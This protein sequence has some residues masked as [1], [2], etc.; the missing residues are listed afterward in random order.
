[1]EPNEERQ[2]QAF[3]P[4]RLVRLVQWLR[5]LLKAT[6]WHGMTALM[7]RIGFVL[8]TVQVFCID[9]QAERV[10]VLRTGEYAAGY[11]PVQGL[12][13]GTLSLRL[14]PLRADVREDAR[15]ELVEEALIEAPPLDAFLVAERYREGPYR[16]FDCTVLVIFCRV[17]ELKLRGETGEG[18]PCWLPLSAA[19]AAFGNKTLRDM[20]ADWRDAPVA[21]TDMGARS[22]GGTSSR[23]FLIGPPDEVQTRPPPQHDMSGADTITAALDRLWAMPLMML[24]AAREL[25]ARGFDEVYQS[26]PKYARELWSGMSAAAR[27]CYR[28]DPRLW[29]DCRLLSARGVA[30]LLAGW[31]EAAIERLAAHSVAG[32]AR[33]IPGGATPETALGVQGRSACEIS[34]DLIYDAE[35]DRVGCFLTRG[36]IAG[37]MSDVLLYSLMSARYLPIPVFH[38]HPIYRTEMGYKQ[39][40]AADFW[41][42]GSLYHRLNGAAVGDCCFFPDGTWT[43]YGITGHGRCFFRRAADPLL[44]P[45]GEPVTTFVDVSLP[46]RPRPG[47]G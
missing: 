26:D 2:Q 31:R 8:S 45:G 15:R 35:E 11:C 20:F 9:P 19:V 41:V 42:M 36:G 34:V 39:A 13:R 14:V 47:H 38:T 5:W 44:P 21:R 40:S 29:R 33:S 30:E 1:M 28:P 18:M 22:R 23:R 24:E 46:E 43:E 12:R 3:R 27:D 6:V 16:Q 10:L 37:V 25:G 4:S 7:D 32:E 17:S